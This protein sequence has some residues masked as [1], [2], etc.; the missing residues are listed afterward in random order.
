MVTR[1]FLESPLYLAVFCLFLSGGAYALWLRSE[2]PLRR[3]I[4]PATIVLIVFLFVLQAAVVTTREELESALRAL[5]QAVD[6][7]DT[8]AIGGA[9][10][11][12]YACDGMDRAG[13]VTFVAEALRHVDVYDVRFHEFDVQSSGAA[14]SLA[15]SASATVR[16]EGVP[17]RINGRW[18]VEW[19][20]GPNGWRIIALRPQEVAGRPVSRLSDL[21]HW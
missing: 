8:S 2:P 21:R 19:K 7:K 9:F 17:G 16:I 14:A 13:V 15:F 18:N 20:H 11:V 12:E 1:L 10:G 4:W 3:R 5:A 6:R